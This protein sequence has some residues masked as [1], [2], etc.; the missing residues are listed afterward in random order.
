MLKFASGELVAA[1]RAEL[2]ENGGRAPAGGVATEPAAGL[3][4][5]L[6]LLGRLAPCLPELELPAVAGGAAK[7]SAAS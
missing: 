6:D 5:L 7:P 4:D 1:V 3:L 2:E